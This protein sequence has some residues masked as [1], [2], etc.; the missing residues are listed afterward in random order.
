MAKKFQFKLEA[1]KKLRAHKADVSKNGF[2]KVSAMRI[3][4]DD[5]IRQVLDIRR[6]MLE[7]PTR[8]TTLDEQL[9]KRSYIKLLDKKLEKMSKER[10]RLSEIEEIKRREYTSKLKDHEAIKIVRDKQEASHRRE[11]N[12]EE[13]NQMEEIALGRFVSDS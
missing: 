4:Q 3:A 9:Q 11:L 13:N 12:R 1:V 5:A 10:Q 6:D 7:A 8:G 2:L